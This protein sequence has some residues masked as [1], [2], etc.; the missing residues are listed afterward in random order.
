MVKKPLLYVCAALFVLGIGG[1]NT[2]A[3]FGEDLSAAG[4]GMSRSAES[5]KQKL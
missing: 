4:R 1:C 3:G 2:V 5:T